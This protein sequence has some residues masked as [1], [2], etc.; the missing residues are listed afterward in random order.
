MKKQG[1]NFMKK[2]KFL[3]WLCL[4][5]VAVALSWGIDQAG[6]QVIVP[7]GAAGFNPNVDYNIPNFAYSP[8]IRKFVDSLP[9]LGAAGCVL[10][11]PL[12]TGTCNENNLGQ[13]IPVAVPDTTTYPDADYYVIGATQYT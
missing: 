2:K 5:L 12:G 8:N 13:Y 6:A 3:M 11:N 4:L 7:V 10:G 1:G 9:G